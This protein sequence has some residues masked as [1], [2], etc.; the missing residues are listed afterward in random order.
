MDSVHRPAG[1]PGTRGSGNTVHQPNAVSCRRNQRARSSAGRAPA[2]Q[3]GGLGF[4]SRRVHSLREAWT[5]QERPPTNPHTIRP[6]GVRE[7]L[8]DPT[9]QT[10]PGTAPVLDHALPIMAVRF[11]LT[12]IRNLD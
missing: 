7:R 10:T 2:L 9:N 1:R 4:K 3:A 11:N 8:G 6:G 5:S 12:C